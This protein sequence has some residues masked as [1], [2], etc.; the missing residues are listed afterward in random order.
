VR[1]IE[2]GIEEAIMSILLV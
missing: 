1:C 2:A